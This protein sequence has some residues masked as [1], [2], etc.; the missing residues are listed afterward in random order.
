VSEVFIRQGIRSAERRKEARMSGQGCPR[1]ARLEQDVPSG[2]VHR[3]DDRSEG[4][5][6]WREDNPNG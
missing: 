5:T 6:K 3:A 1:K 2:L 4:T